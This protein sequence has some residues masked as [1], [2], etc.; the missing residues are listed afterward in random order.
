MEIVFSTARNGLATCSRNGRL[1]HSSYDPRVEAERFVE[2]LF[3]GRDEERPPATFVLAGPCIDYLSEI[4]GRRVPGAT[5]VSVQFSSAFKGREVGA[6]GARWYPGG[7]LGI[8]AFLQGFLDDERMAGL[9][10]V[11]WPPAVA[12][13]PVLAEATRRALRVTLDRIAASAATTRAYGRRW[14][15]NACRSFL[16]VDALVVPRREGAPILVVGAGP[17]LEA[18]IEDVLP[19][20]DRFRIFAVSSALRALRARGLEP[21]LVVATDGGYWS[22]LHLY[23]LAEAGTPR[24]SPLSALPSASLRNEILLLD[25]GWFPETELCA[26]LG[27]PM[28]IPGHGTVTG[29]ALALAARL[30]TGPLIAAGFDFAASAA[31][32]HAGPHGFDE[33]VA[34][35]ET[36]LAT[37]EGRR[38]SRLHDLHPEPLPGSEWRSS[39]SLAAYATALEADRAALGRPV[40][41]LRPSP[42]RLAGFTETGVEELAALVEGLPEPGRETLLAETPGA[43]EREALLVRLLREWRA[44]SVEALRILEAGRIPEPRIGDFLRS[45]DLVDWAAARRGISDRGSP[46]PVLD[47]LRNTVFRFLDELEGSFAS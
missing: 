1:L 37:S 17:S 36:R 20:R 8:E 31:S 41:R 25:Q 22:R 12:E 10:L 45:V 3:K 34:H 29:T 14:I 40:H 18:A 4:I 28:G 24:A 21:D 7:E 27:S 38:W 23:P 2:D 47:D 32:S 19:L 6:G 15:R 9:A 11:E 46:G 16:L 26:L 39:R 42:L 30:G 33:V 35:G 13:F 43:T 44:R 5:I